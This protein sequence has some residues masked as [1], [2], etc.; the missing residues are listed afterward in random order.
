MGSVEVSW[1]FERRE[2]IESDCFESRMRAVT[3][4]DLAR[5]KGFIWRKV[6]ALAPMRRMCLV[7]ILRLF[8]ARI[9]DRKERWI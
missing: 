5:R 9:I 2:S 3:D 6:L 8:V 7:A 1:T 4:Y